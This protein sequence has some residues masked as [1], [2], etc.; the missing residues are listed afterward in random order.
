[1]PLMNLD[2]LK[3]FHAVARCRSFSKAAEALYLT[4]PTVSS[5]IQKLEHS[6]K[7]PLFDRS[8]RQISLTPKGEILYNYTRRLFDL[9]GEIDNAFQNFTELQSGHVSVSASAVVGTYYLPPLIAEYRRRYPGIELHLRIGNSEQVARDVRGQEADF[10]I[11]ARIVGAGD[12]VQYQ[13]L[14]EPYRVLASPSSRWCA[15]GRPLLPSEFAK[16]CII[17]REK[18]AR[19]Q[20]KLEEWLAEQGE[21][22]FSGSCSVNS[23]ELAKQ[24]AVCGMG[25]I[26]LPEMTVRRELEAGQLVRVEVERFN[27][28]TGYYLNYLKTAN[29]S[30]AALKLVMLLKENRRDFMAIL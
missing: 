30:P 6:L 12:L 23:M 25:L 17:T 21:T 8:R 10:G 29:L 19:S 22:H 28:S 26:V 24:L 13:L 18:G 16:G 7:A 11:C 9:F 20:A 27:L 2:W 4:Q 1:M 3:T 15:M 14:S 5:Q